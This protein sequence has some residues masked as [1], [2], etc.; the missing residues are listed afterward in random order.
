[1]KK[2]YIVPTITMNQENQLEGVFAC[3]NDGTDFGNDYG[4]SKNS[5][6]VPAVPLAPTQFNW[7]S[8]WDLIR[9]FFRHWGC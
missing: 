1:M 4:K 2:K 7:N 8:I 6:S 9:K 3:W 5:T